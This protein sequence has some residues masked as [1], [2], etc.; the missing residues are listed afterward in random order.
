MYWCLIISGRVPTFVVNKVSST[1]PM[2]VAVLRDL[3]ERDYKALSNEER[4]RWQKMTL[5]EYIRGG[6]PE[7]EE[8][9]EEGEGEGEGEILQEGGEDYEILQEEKETET[10]QMGE[11]GEVTESPRSGSESESVSVQESVATMSHD[12]NL[13]L[14][15]LPACTLTDLLTLMLCLD[16]YRISN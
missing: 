14:S 2:C 13:P 9:D 16:S 12:L 1:Q 11:S 5:K 10:E 4:Q 15:Q 3:V 8:N 7:E 6:Q